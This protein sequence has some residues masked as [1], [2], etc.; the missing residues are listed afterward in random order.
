MHVS[1]WVHGAPAPELS[2][3]Y[4]FG[5]W[6]YSDGLGW[7]L[8]WMQYLNLY[9][10]FICINCR[11]P[12]LSWKPFACKG[13]HLS[14][15]LEAHVEC[16]FIQ[17]GIDV[18]FNSILYKIYYLLYIYHSDR[19]VFFFGIAWV[20]KA[21]ASQSCSVLH[22]R[23]PSWCFR[24]CTPAAILRHSILPACALKVPEIDPWHP[25][26]EPAA[27]TTG[28]PSGSRYTSFWAEPDWTRLLIRSRKGIH[29][30]FFFR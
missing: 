18:T 14:S 13:V 1:V 10:S 26:W 3:V 8:S 28:L 22:M 5:P 9:I 2:L 16:T 29:S 21:S 4:M 25:G 20:T 19:W 12:V 27:L 23:T 6:P 15:L 17:D 7:T 24:L 11:Q 30:G